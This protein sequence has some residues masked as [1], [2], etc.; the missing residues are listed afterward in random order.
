MS[1]TLHRGPKRYDYSEEKDGWLYTRDS[2]ALSDLLNSEIGQIVGRQ[3]EL[4]LDN[5]SQHTN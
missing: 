2:V 1:L 4:G 3:V 5:V